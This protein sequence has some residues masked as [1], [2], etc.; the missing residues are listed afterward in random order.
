M[1]AG[2]YTGTGAG[3][4]GSPNELVFPFAPRLL[5]LYRQDGTKMAQ[6]SAAEAES[7]G[8]AGGITFTM[9]EKAASAGTQQ[10]PTPR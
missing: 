3:G 8:T 6:L 9:Q 10:T 1:M 7:S 2:S 4:Q 5:V